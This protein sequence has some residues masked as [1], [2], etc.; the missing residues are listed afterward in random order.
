LG[1]ELTDPQI[2]REELPLPTDFEL[3]ILRALWNLGPSTVREL[4][5]HLGGEKA[6]TTVLSMM[7]VMTQK[8]FVV[9]NKS[10]TA[11]VYSVT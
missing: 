2:G 8:G 5:S 9:P 7:Q 4:H 6:Y 11:F 3:T 10:G 1:V